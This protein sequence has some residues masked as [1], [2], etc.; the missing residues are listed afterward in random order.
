MSVWMSQTSFHTNTIE[1]MW[2]F[3]NKLTWKINNK[4]FQFKNWNLFHM[5]LFKKNVHKLQLCLIILIV[6]LVQY[7]DYFSSS[8]K[9]LSN[10]SIFFEFGCSVEFNPIYCDRK[11]FENGILMPVINVW[12]C[13]IFKKHNF[14]SSFY[15]S[16]FWYDFYRYWADSIFNRIK[17]KSSIFS[18]IFL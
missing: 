3:L 11:W 12:A 17:H 5:T 8:I 15:H 18:H 6:Y 14:R 16:I 13:S 10:L 1:R 2:T 7:F 4:H 9:F